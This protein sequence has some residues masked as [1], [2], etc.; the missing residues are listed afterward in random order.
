MR[1]L[2]DRVAVPP[3]PT[4]KWDQFRHLGQLHHALRNYVQRSLARRKTGVNVLLHG[5]P[6]NGKT[7]LTRALARDLECELFE[8]ATEDTD[9]DPIG[10][11][12]RLQALRVLQSFLKGRRCLVTFDEIED[13]FPRPHS[14]FLSS[15]RQQYAKGWVNRLVES[16]QVV[17]FWITNAVEALDPALVRH[18]DL[19]VEVRPP[20]R[21]IREALLRQL[22]ISLSASTIAKVVA[23]DALSPAVVQRAALVT[24][25]AAADAP[26]LDLSRCLESI[27]NQTL[28]AQGH[29][30]LAGASPVGELYDPD[31]VNCDLDPR[32][33]LSGLRSSSSA[34][35][36]LFGPPGTG[37]TAFAHWLAREVGVPLQAKRASDLLSPYVGMTE[38]RIA[39]TFQTA[40]EAG[41]AL[42]IDEVDSFLQDRGSSSRTWEVTQVN[43]F[44]CQI[45]QFPGLFLASTNLLSRFDP[46]AFRRFDFKAKFEF[47]RREQSRRLLQA[48]L[49]A[50]GLPAP[51]PESVRRLDLLANLTPGDFAAVARRHRVSPMAD[52]RAWID[53]LAVECQLKPSETRH[54]LGFGA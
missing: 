16:N 54:V 14:F 50:I 11:P 7:E 52:A 25:E 17:T 49:S 13:V 9:G 10:A 1:A 29:P 5:E 37:K 51:A 27:V 32:A 35:V 36:C 43:E 12:Q 44:L 24:A 3:A 46:A 45:E 38:R 31:Y 53:A 42:L 26:D 47:L 6:G 28:K 20:P 18:F 40:T 34:R 2:R 48:H 39:E 8:V 22:P 15:Q 41:T 33:L 4:V 21:Q 30:L 23:C 19:V